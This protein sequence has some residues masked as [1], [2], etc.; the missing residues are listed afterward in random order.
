MVAKQYRNSAFARFQIFFLRLPHTAVPS[1]MTRRSI[2]R[3]KNDKPVFGSSIRAAKRQTDAT[4]E[5]H[6]SSATASGSNAVHAGKRR[7]WTSLGLSRWRDPNTS[8]ALTGR[9]ASAP[10]YMHCACFEADWWGRA[11]LCVLCMQPVPSKGLSLERLDAPGVCKE[12]VPGPS[13]SITSV[14]PSPP[15]VC[16]ATRR[17]CQ[18]QP[19]VRRAVLEPQTHHFTTPT[20][21]PI[22][23]FFAATI[24]IRHQHAWCREV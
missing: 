14:Q 2:C 13:R 21:H 12:C 11:Q 17:E 19:G 22:P 15:P 10:R 8:R 4:C 7:L 18:I 9:V 16:L 5:I 24:G 1:I 3:Y 6:G 20:S 23:P